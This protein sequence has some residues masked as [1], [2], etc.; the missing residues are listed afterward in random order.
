MARPS[1]RRRIEPDVAPA[2]RPDWVVTGL[3]VAG[4]LVSGYLTW[5]K[6]TGAGAALCVAGSGCDIVQA[7]RYALFLGVPT[8]AWGFAVYV[9]IGALAVTGLGGRSW[10]IAFLFAAGGVGFSLYLTALSVFELGTTCVWCLASAA[11]LVAIA[12]TL[13]RRRP[14][15]QGRKSPYRAPR[16]ATYG[17]LAAVATVVAGAFVFAA[18]FSAP[19]G[20]QSAL[21]RHLAETKAVMYGAFW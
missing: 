19:A 11:I 9:V 18:P 12:V 21:A 6:L 8:A 14:G 17:V 10:L 7:S 15:P 3:V 1:P 16:L 20:F 13:Q 4:L 5:L 2:A